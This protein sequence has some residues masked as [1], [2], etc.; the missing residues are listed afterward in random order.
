M[1]DEKLVLDNI[2]LIYAVLKRM[3]L[4]HKLD[5]YFDI[6]MIGLVQGARTFK[7]E[8]GYSATTYLYTC[9]YNEISKAVKKKELITVSIDNKVD[10]KHTYNEVIPD[11]KNTENIYF[12][13]YDTIIIHEAIKKLTKEEQ[14]V[15]N[16]CFGLN[17]YSG[18]TTYQKDLG[19]ILKMS[20]SNVSRIKFRALKKLKKELEKEL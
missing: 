11:K 6:G 20:Q 17:E 12:L 14:L 2:N 5:E 9:I 18:K 8:L 15:I 4:Y 16:A 7:K 10:E 1:Y 3:K 19:E 13:K